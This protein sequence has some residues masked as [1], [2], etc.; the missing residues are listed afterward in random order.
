MAPLPHIVRKGG[1]LVAVEGDRGEV[2]LGRSERE[3]ESA[4]PFVRPL[5]G[6]R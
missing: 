2:D 5:W 4:E 6:A 1:E 3:L